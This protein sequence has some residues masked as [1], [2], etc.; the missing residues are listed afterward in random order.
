MKFKVG[1]RVKYKQNGEIFKITVVDRSYT[2]FPYRAKNKSGY[3]CWFEEEE[4]E[5]ANYTYE[6]LK[7]SPIGTKV[8]FEKGNVLLKTCRNRFENEIDVS[9]IDELTNFKNKYYGKIIKIEEPTYT[10]IYEYKPEIL[11][12]VEKRYL[13]NVIR[14]FRDSVKSIEKFIFSTGAAK[15]IIKI[16]RSESFWYISLPPFEK[17]K[18]Y[19]NMEEDKEYTLEELG[20]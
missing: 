11:D 8:T 20:L 18:M 4:L 1:D 6:D 15:I 9:K 10:T 13:K 12:E 5:S 16:E 19:K 7:K 3:E 2:N 17:Y 14:P